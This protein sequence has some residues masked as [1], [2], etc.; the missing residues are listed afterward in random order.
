MIIKQ[1]SWLLIAGTIA[2]EICNEQLENLPKKRFTNDALD[3]L[4]DPICPGL[5]SQML[6]LNS[7]LKLDFWPNTI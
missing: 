6:L 7:T 3:S 2:Q 1:F 4:E 5:Y